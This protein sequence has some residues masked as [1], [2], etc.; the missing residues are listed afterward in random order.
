MTGSLL[1]AAPAHSDL[2]NRRQPDDNEGVR[3]AILL[4]PILVAAGCGHE[5]SI[6]G[7]WDTR[8]DLGV[9]TMT[10]N[11]DNTFVS[12]RDAP[13]ASLHL[14]GVYEL[15]GDQLRLHIA[16]WQVPRGPKLSEDQTDAMDKALRPDSFSTV[17]WTDD[18]HIKL[19]GPQGELTT[20]ERITK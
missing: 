6:V 3:R 8:A 5:R 16:R 19:L 13:M 18:N 1:G 17:K 2:E 4:L 10:F 14:E 9:G 15:K 11:P 12:H 7:V 20:G